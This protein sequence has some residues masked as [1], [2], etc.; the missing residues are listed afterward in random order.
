MALEASEKSVTAC[1]KNY[2]KSVNEYSFLST[3]FISIRSYRVALLIEYPLL[4]IIVH[5]SLPV[6]CKVGY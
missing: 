2:N 6:D 4:S 5:A 3:V 1:F